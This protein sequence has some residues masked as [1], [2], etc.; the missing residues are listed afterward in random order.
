MRIR[1]MYMRVIRRIMA[2]YGIARAEMP[3]RWSVLPNASFA[4]VL[5]YTDWYATKSD[6]RFGRY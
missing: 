2:K 3:P 4:D 1:D 5:R 6:Y